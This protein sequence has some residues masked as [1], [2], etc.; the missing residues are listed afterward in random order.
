[1][2]QVVPPL[3][4]FAPGVQ[5]LSEGKEWQREVPLSPHWLI[6]SLPWHSLRL[7]TI[8]AANRFSH[9]ARLRSGRLYSYIFTALGHEVR[10]RLGH[11]NRNLPILTPM[12]SRNGITFNERTGD[13]TC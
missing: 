13:V 12:R 11:V 7:L 4:R 3:W 8:A 9:C 6:A 5:K 1:M 10:S 2:A